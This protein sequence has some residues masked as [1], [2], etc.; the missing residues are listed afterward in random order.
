M[1]YVIYVLLLTAIPLLCVWFAPNTFVDKIGKDLMG[2]IIGSILGFYASC[3]IFLLTAVRE[4]EKE[5]HQKDDQMKA[6]VYHLI[7]EISLNESLLQGLWDDADITNILLAPPTHCGVSEFIRAHHLYMIAPGILNIR[8]ECYL[9]EQQ[10]INYLNKHNMLK[11]MPEDSR[12]QK[13]EELK[14]YQIL[15]IKTGNILLEKLE[16][17][18][19][20]CDVGKEYIDELCPHSPKTPEN[21]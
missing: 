3:G 6:L 8:T 17:T 19:K 5:K 14:T 4:R 9:Y 16:K 11:N 1:K 18:P 13:L 20:I 7:S 10:V 21:T 15:I 2:V 12:A